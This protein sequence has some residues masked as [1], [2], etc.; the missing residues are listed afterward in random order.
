M[1]NKLI[2][3]KNDLHNVEKFNA[4]LGVLK[5]KITFTVIN[6]ENTF[7]E[8]TVASTV[9]VRC[10]ERGQPDF[11]RI[12]LDEAAL[13]AY[14]IRPRRDELGTLSKDL[15]NCSTSTRCD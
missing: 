2:F 12:H 8:V 15:N 1:I 4:P 11:G 7:Y 3:G 14:T 6:M 9:G 10:V 5:F 13:I